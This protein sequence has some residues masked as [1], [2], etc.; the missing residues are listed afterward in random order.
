MSYFDSFPCSALIVTRFARNQVAPAI[1][2]RMVEKGSLMVSYQPLVHKNMVNFF[3]LA[4]HC[5]P[6]PTHEDMDF[7]LN[8]IER[9][10]R[11]LDN[12]H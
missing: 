8:E 9:L 1:K 4:L 6:P 10:G 2:K 11:D 7:V 12:I 5:Q 3:R